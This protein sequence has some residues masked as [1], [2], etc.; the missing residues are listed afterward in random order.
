MAMPYYSVIKHT[1]THTCTNKFQP[2]Y[3]G[4]G[5]VKPIS[6]VLLFSQFFT[7]VKTIIIYPIS[8]SYVTGVATVPCQIWVWFLKIQHVLLQNQEFLTL[9]WRHNGRDGVSNRQSYHCLLNWLF[10]YRSKKT[11]KLRV[12]GLCA[13]NSP[14]TGEFP[15]QMAS[16]AE[17][18]SIWWRHHERRN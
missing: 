7:I 14:V 9:Q 1:K 15:A 10:S 3:P 4:I 11:S 6:S 17:N 16:N 8:R 13:V 5:V 2:L 12:T 18:F